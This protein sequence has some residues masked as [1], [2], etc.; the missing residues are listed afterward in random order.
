VNREVILTP[1]DPAGLG[2][3]GGLVGDATPT[4]TGATPWTV[5][6]RPRRKSFIEYTGIELHQLVIPMIFDQNENADVEASCMLLDIWRYPSGST[7]KPPV[8]RLEGPVPAFWTVP[9]WVLMGVT[10]G[11][12]IRDN[13]G[14]RTQQYADLTILE[15]SSGAATVK[16]I[17]QIVQAATSA[18]T[19]ATATS[20]ALPAASHRS[21]IVRGGDTLYGIASQQLG[22]PQRWPEIANLNNVHD[23]RKLAIGQTL[24]L[25]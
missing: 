20:P 4:Y 11:S 1:V 2:I 8:L 5:V 18:P 24:M 6:N 10:F 25:P 23:P 9:L 21:Y 22:N 13:T 3:H 7:G 17:V 12:A 19:P 14:R 15:Y 16:S